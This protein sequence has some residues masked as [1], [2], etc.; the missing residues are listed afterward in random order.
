MIMKAQK[1]KT[2][3]NGNISTHPYV[4]SQP[5]TLKKY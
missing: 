1:V 4:Q 3:K 2:T 5:V